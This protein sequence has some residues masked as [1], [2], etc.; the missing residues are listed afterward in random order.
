M[1]KIFLVTLIISVIIL[2]VIPAVAFGQSIS[3]NA[4][5]DLSGK[6][7][8]GAAMQ[9]GYP[10]IFSDESEKFN[11]DAGIT[12]IQFVRLLHRALNININYFAAPDVSDSFDDMRNTDVGANELIDF[13]TVG[14][15]AGGGSFYPDKPIL[16]EEMIHWMMN[17]L[18]YK[19]DGKYPMPLMM[20]APFSDDSR[21]SDVYRGEIYSS[22]VLKLVNGRGSNMLFPK[23]GA[24]RAEAVIVVSRLM[25]LLGTCE[26][27]VLV[28][29]SAVS[30]DN[31]AVTMSL[32]I[33]NNTDRSIV[34]SHTSGQKFDFKLFDAK[35]SNVYTWSADKMFIQVLNE[36]T[37][38]AGEEIVFSDIIDSGANEVI[39]TAVSLK[40]YIV[41]TSDNFKINLDGY[42]SEVV[43]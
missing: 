32:T 9:Y 37:I 42:A 2:T 21:I 25:L 1:K 24:T 23:D 30:A 43:E 29:A 18:S 26:S 17:A 31:G 3:G 34:I 12:R 8:A 10:E 22:V 33:H 38:G 14:I 6:W 40:A 19:T 5:S 7:Y 11:G 16:R 35:G 39:H 27:D 28:S 41:G 4:Y 36:T 20:P 15:V 13:A